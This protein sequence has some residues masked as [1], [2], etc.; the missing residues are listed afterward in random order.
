[1]GALF[2]CHGGDIDDRW[3]GGTWYIIG[4][5]EIETFAEHIVTVKT[6]GTTG[7]SHSFKT[8]PIL[9][10]SVKLGFWMVRRMS[11]AQCL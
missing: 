11:G 7:V 5:V 1:M 2:V 6:G 10:T 4:G 3:W 8:A 9:N